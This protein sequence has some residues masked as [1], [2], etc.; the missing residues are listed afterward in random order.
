MLMEELTDYPVIPLNSEGK[1]F[2]PRL[3]NKLKNHFDKIIYFANN[4]S[5]KEINTG[6]ELAKKWKEMYGIEYIS[7]P[8]NTA[9]DISDYYKKYGKIETKKL[10]N[11]WK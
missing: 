11:Q 5:D 7:T 3:W 4:D 9:S 6:I 1:W 8:D 2:E 10:I